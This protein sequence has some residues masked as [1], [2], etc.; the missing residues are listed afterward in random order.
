MLCTQGTGGHGQ[1]LL[2]DV[3]FRG[4]PVP[5]I[6]SFHGLGTAGY[7]PWRRRVA[8]K[9]L[10]HMTSHLFTLSRQSKELLVDQWGWPPE[11]TEIVPN[12][13]DTNCFYPVPKKNDERFVIGS[14][15][16]L[17]TVKNHKM[18]LEAC[19]PLLMEGHDLEIRIAGE[20]ELRAELVDL[21]ADLNMEKN[22]VMPGRI[23]NVSGFL[24]ELDMFVLSS[25]SE[26][27]PNALNEA[28]ACGIPSVGT[29]VGC[30]EDLLDGGR[31]GKLI[32]SDD[33]FALT[34]AIRTYL[35]D[36]SLRHSYGQLGLKH[37]R[38]NYSFD[39]MLKRY[40]EMYCRFSKK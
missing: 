27:H 24:N 9:A 21:A 2:L 23:D 35:L 22:L 28:M 36:P 37:V 7:M 31:C 15:G 34:K 30:V 39:L 40:R 13:V 19:H 17:R 12:G 33:V 38:E 6:Y 29:N 26:Q 4:P 3:I 16:N 32:E 25:K 8:S 1:I 14:V 11:R 18:I 20:G 5:L 10:V